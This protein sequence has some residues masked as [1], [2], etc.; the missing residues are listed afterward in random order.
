MC[1]RYA[2]FGRVAASESVRSGH[3][4]SVEE[5]QH[6]PNWQGHDHRIARPGKRLRA[7]SARQIRKMKALNKKIEATRAK[8]H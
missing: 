1:E 3:A 5:A 8:P 6:R 2:D 7:S 4:S